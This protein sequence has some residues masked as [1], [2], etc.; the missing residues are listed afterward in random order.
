MF[1]FYIEKKPETKEK[2]EFGLEEV[3]SK[4]EDEE[5]K[6]PVLKGR[7]FHFPNIVHT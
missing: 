5:L 2:K 1:I 6:Y 4:L 3:V 7:Y